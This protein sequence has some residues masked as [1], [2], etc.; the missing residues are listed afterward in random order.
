[1]KRSIIIFNLLALVFLMSFIS[2]NT[3]ESYN[4]KQVNENFTFCQTC[5]D[6][7]YITLS[8]IETPNSTDI[9]NS[10][11]TSVG[12]G[13]FCYNYTPTQIGR[14]DFAGI[15]DGC[16]KTF[17]VSIE[18]TADGNVYNTGD[19]LIRIFVSIFFILMMLGFHKMANA[20]NYE[21]WYENIKEKY[22]TRNFV[23]W[24]LAAIAYNIMTNTYIIYFL[25]GLPIML[26]LTDLVYIYNVTS[27]TLYMQS[28]LYIYI[29]LI[30]VLGVVFLAFLQEWF[31]D[32]IEELQN[33]DWGV[34]D[35]E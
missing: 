23:K 35:Y 9:I 1:M 5:Q 6:S 30:A 11:M 33:L 22:T 12:G 32:F 24:S 13:S 26:I 21:K 2:A 28:L 20:I 29:S 31:M 3:L 16:L 14:Y 17:A 25:L 4:P 7:S 10:N 15:S 8:Q 27:I 19:S 34:D 18:V